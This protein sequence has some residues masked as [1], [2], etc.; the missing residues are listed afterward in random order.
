[1][2]IKI[3]YNN[4]NALLIMTICCKLKEHQQHQCV[5]LES[6]IWQ[7]ASVEQS[8]LACGQHFFWQSN[9]FFTILLILTV[10]RSGTFILCPKDSSSLLSAFF[11]HF[12]LVLQSAIVWRSVFVWESD[13]VLP[14]WQSVLFWYSALVF[15]QP[16]SIHG[17]SH[18][19]YTNR[20]L[21]FK[22]IPKTSAESKF[23]GQGKKV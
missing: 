19:I 23:F 8:A 14:V 16:L 15:Y 22:K 11:W 20:N 12:S 4:F 9:F 7:W 2:I 10:S 21:R 3:K 17:I 5:S 18:K 6:F 1:M 13:Q